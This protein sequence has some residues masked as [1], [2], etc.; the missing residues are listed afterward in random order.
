MEAI[1]KRGYFLQEQHHLLLMVLKCCRGTALLY[2]IKTEVVN[3]G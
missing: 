3:T 1:L 2:S